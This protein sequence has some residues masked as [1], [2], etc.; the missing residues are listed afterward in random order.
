MIRHPHDY[1]GNAVGERPC[2]VRA[3]SGPAKRQDAQHDQY[4][5]D[6]QF[7]PAK[8]RNAFSLFFASCQN[9]HELF[10]GDGFLFIEELGQLIQLGTVVL[11]NLLGLFVLR[12]T[13]STTLRSISFW[14][15]GE[16]AREVSPPRY[17]LFT[18][19]MATMSNSSLMP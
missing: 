12:L 11:Q 14:V 18:V 7:K 1:G 6:D 9:L 5:A 10:A 16:Q 13:S 19:S 2:R 4:D 3:R 8:Y 15:S 17:W